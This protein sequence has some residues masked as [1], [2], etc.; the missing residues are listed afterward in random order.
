MTSR[1]ESDESVQI[2]RAKEAMNA[3][4]TVER[5]SEIQ[6]KHIQTYLS[7]KLNY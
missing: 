2:L 5:N 7:N 3:G 4:G 6:Q 1:T